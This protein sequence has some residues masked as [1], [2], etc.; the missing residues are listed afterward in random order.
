MSPTSWPSSGSATARR[1]RRTPSATC[2]R[3]QRRDREPSRSFRGPHAPPS[4]CARPDEPAAQEKG[5]RHGEDDRGP[6]RAG[7]PA[8]ALERAPPDALRGAMPGAGGDRVR[9]AGGPA[10]PPRVRRPAPG[11]D[12]AAAHDGRDARSGGGGDGVPLHRLGR[13]GGRL[14]R[15]LGG[16]GGDAAVGVR[17][18]DRRGPPRQ[19][20]LDPDGGHDGP[21]V[22]DRHNRGRVPRHLPRRDHPDGRLPGARAGPAGRPAARADVREVHAP[23]VRRADRPGRGA[24]G[25]PSAGG[26]GIEMSE[27]NTAIVQSVYAALN[28]H[29]LDAL[30]GVIAE[31]VVLHGMEAQGLAALKAEMRAYFA[32]VPDFTVTVER[33]IADRDRVVTWVVCSGT[34]TGELWG[35]PPT[36]RTLAVP[37]IDLCRIEDGKVAE[38]W[39]LSDG[40]AM[41]RQLGLEPQAEPDPAG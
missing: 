14:A 34:H 27:Q 1:R 13:Q 33:L 10:R 39:V 22:R 25:L 16:D 20:G 6:Q 9:P 36:G 2:R 15:P 17:V 30:D 32:G 8:S 28:A 3:N 35:I 18:R 5:G 21:P 37:E 40:S 12:H 38:F 11:R 26:G 4:P 7:G 19:A 31:D 23:G 24:G 29:D 41:M